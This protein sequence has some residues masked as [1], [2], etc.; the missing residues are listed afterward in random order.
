MSCFILIQTYMKVS[1]HFHIISYVCNHRMCLLQLLACYYHYQNNQLRKA[2]KKSKEKLDRKAKKKRTRPKDLTERLEQEKRMVRALLDNILD[3]NEN[4][5]L[6][7][8]TNGDNTNILIIGDS[9]IKDIGENLKGPQYR[10]KNLTNWCDVIYR[11]GPKPKQTTGRPRPIFVSFSYLR[12]KHM[13]LPNAYK[14]KDV[15]ERKHLPIRRYQ[16]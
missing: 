4:T 6:T 10:T 11:K 13:V 7:A 1:G 12:L 5:K 16:C 3:I 14:L 2:L 15:P 9:N 8:Q